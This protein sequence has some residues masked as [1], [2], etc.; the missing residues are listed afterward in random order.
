MN[1]PVL[2]GLSLVYSGINYLLKLFYDKKKDYPKDF[3]Q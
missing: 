3:C 1:L 2:V